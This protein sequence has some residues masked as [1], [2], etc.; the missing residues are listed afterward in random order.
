[1]DISTTIGG[2]LGYFNFGARIFTRAFLLRYGVDFSQN[3]SEIRAKFGKDMIFDF[4]GEGHIKNVKYTLNADEL[5]AS[6]E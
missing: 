1:M 4:D 3:G 6:G 5:I 2:C